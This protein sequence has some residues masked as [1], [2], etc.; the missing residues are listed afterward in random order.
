MIPYGTLLNVLLVILGG[1]IGIFTKK[2]ISLHLQKKIFIVLG[3]FTIIIGVSMCFNFQNYVIVIISLIL[4]SK[5]GNYF[6][7]DLVI[8]NLTKNLK[9][10]LKIN[11]NNF[12][13][14]ILTSFLLFCVG[15]M[16]IV[17]SIEEGLGKPPTILY[18]KS[19][20]DGVS[21][22]LLSSIFGVGVIFSVFPMI[23]FQGSI[24]LLTFYFRDFI[25]NQLINDIESVGG[26]LIIV[27]GLNI[28][29]FKRVNAINLL[30]SLIFVVFIYLASSTFV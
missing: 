21:S 15:S 14:G 16:T 17:G 29:G 23:I 19:V 28:L 9:E 30:P 12:T 10:K 27:M 24:T 18:T 20:M 8:K 4:G 11:S 7:L 25:P 5:F 13:E 2:I 3:L 1:T 26:I 6:N 22:V